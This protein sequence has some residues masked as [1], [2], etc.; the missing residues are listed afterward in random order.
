MCWAIQVLLGECSQ[1]V[2]K[3]PGTSCVGVG[4][5]VAVGAQRA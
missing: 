3:I 5:A 4:A 2:A 1:A